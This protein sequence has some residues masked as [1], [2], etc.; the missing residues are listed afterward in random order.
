MIIELF[1]ASFPPK[2]FIGAELYDIAVLKYLQEQGHE[3]SVILPIDESW[4]F[5]GISVN[6]KDRKKPNIV[7]TH[8]D[9]SA[10]AFLRAS[11]S[12]AKILGIGHNTGRFSNDAANYGKYDAIILNS[13]FMKDFFGISKDKKCLIIVPPT[14]EPQKRFLKTRENFVS[15]NQ[16]REKGGV[17]FAELA[18]WMPKEKFVGVLGGWGGQFTKELPNL[19]YFEHGPNAVKEVLRKAKALVVASAEE[20]WGMAAAEALSHGVPVVYYKHLHGVAENAGEAGVAVSTGDFGLLVKT[21]EGELPTRE[22]CIE[23]ANKNRARHLDGLRELND[24]I[25]GT[26]WRHG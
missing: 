22:A 8:L 6:P 25:E 4:E 2:R 12:G 13:N 18:E 1:A 15:V 5:D 21:L 10:P 3:V 24:L 14:P 7:L 23:Q 11:Q 26:Q 16:A 17:A 20:S 19:S 9:Y